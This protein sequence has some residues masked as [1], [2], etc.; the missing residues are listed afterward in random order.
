MS[1]CKKMTMGLIHPLH[2]HFSKFLD[3][4]P[5]GSI[6]V[7][8]A[9]NVSANLWAAVTCKCT[10]V[11]CCPVRQLF[12]FTCYFI[13]AW[14]N[15]MKEWKSKLRCSWCKSPERAEMRVGV[16][17][18]QTTAECAVSSRLPSPADVALQPP[19]AQPRDLQCSKPDNTGYSL[20]IGRLTIVLQRFDAVGWDM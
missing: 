15:K 5:P 2:S 19:T 7:K 13:A 6:A 9:D 4:P 11:P 3:P 12:D 20:W 16:A 1:I 10:L 8:F 17:G 18:G 14:T